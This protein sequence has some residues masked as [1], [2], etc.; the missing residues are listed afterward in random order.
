MVEGTGS[1]STKNTQLHR[2]VDREVGKAG[3]PW[4]LCGP[5]WA[6]PT[7]ALVRVHSGVQRAI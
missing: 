6:F 3:T 4:R 7:H 1:L 5:G 2:D